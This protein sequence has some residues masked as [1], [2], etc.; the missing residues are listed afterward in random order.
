M[1]TASLLGGLL[2]LLGLFTSAESQACRAALEGVLTAQSPIHNALVED[3]LA[4][5]S[6]GAK[7]LVGLTKQWLTEHP[8]DANLENIQK[9]DKAATAI[10]TAEDLDIARGAF[11][12]LSQGV[13]AIIRA[14]KRLQDKWQLF[15]CPMVAK[16]QGFWVQPKGEDLANPYMGTQMPGCGS[17]KPW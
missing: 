10:A 9:I 6:E 14:D 11:I 7:V 4:K 3:D 2:A 8:T 17:D 1:K 12:Q 5:A 13:I 15:F 16:K